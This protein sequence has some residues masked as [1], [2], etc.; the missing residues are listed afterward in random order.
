MSG[1]IKAKTKHG[2]ISIDQLAEIQPG[3]AKIMQEVALRYYY[4]YYAAKGGNWKLAAHELNQVRTSFGVAKVTR[5]KF[6]ED[7]QAFESEY[8]LPIFKAIQKQDWGEFRTAYR[9][10]MKGSDKYHDKTGHE[11][12][13]F[14]L[15]KDPPAHMYLGPMEKFQRNE[16]DGEEF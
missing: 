11:Y 14:V 7:L 3:M 12:I 2:E 6:T 4:A 13:R 9:E 1:E 16:D 10:G 15:P 5:P 8:L